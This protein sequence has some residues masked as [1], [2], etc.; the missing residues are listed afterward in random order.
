MGSP[1]YA[2]NRVY[3]T[4]L[5]LRPLF[6]KG[7]PTMPAVTI[8]EE[9]QPKLENLMSARHSAY[10]LAKKHK[11]GANQFTERFRAANRD[12]VAARDASK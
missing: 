4:F 3:G 1:V 7:A 6:S 10:Q 8:T 5:H 11:F 12:Y 2:I 9:T